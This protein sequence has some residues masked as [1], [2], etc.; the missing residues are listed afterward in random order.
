MYRIH[1]ESTSKEKLPPIIKYLKNKAETRCLR[2][3]NINK[4]NSFKEKVEENGK[5]YYLMRRRCE[6]GLYFIKDEKSDDSTE[7]NDMTK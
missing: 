3:A 5:T 6:V 1:K 4:C 7:E 2:C